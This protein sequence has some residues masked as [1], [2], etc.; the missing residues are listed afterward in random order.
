VEIGTPQ[1]VERIRML[2]DLVRAT[3]TNGKVAMTAAVAAL[4][5]QTRVKVLNTARTFNDFTRHNDPYGENELHGRILAHRPNSCRASHSTEHRPVRHWFFLMH[6]RE[7]QY[8]CI[9]TKY[10]GV[11]Q[12][13]A[14]NFQ[15]SF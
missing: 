2:N 5:E 7:R 13:C 15:R 14:G 10:P 12:T 9:E 6:I 11:H 8:P 1:T 4:D 3:F